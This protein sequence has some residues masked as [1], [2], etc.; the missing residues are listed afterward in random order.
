MENLL[1]SK[2]EVEQYFQ[3]ARG[4]KESEFNNFIR[5]A[6]QFELKKIMPTQLYYDVVANPTKYQDLLNE[7]SYECGGVGYHHSGLKAVLV[8]FTYALYLLKSNLQDTSYNVVV[9]QDNYSNP[10]EYKER[11]DWYT[12]H[13]QQGNE[14]YEE[15][16][17][18]IDCKG[19]IN[20]P[21][22]KKQKTK[23]KTSVIK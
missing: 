11:K 2:K 13:I 1:I 4:R 22:S 3:I 14:L 20:V 23:F 15:I 10:A 16:K 9:K 7:G 21:C 6:Q 8:Q 17:K 12:R 18:Y 19:F 5:E